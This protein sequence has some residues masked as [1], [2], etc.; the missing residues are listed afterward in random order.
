M[1]PVGARLAGA[2]GTIGVVATTG[3]AVPGAVDAWPAPS[4]PTDTLTLELVEPSFAIP[5]DTTWRAVYTVAGRLADVV[6][7]TTTTTT[8]TT[9]TT[10]PTTTRPGRGA[11]P[12]PDRT[13]TSTAPPT[14]TALAPPSVDAR[15]RVVLYRSLDE[16]SELAATIAGDLP[17][18]I[19]RFELPLD[20]ALSE[21]GN[22]S[23]LSVEVP[24]TT[25][26]NPDPALSMRLPGLYPIGVQLVV[27]GEV[28]A[29]HVTFVDRLPIDPPTNPPLSVAILAATDDPGPAPT[30]TELVE[31]REDLEAIADV[32]SS[33][34]GPVTVVLPPVLMADLSA[35]DE[36]AETLVTALDGAEL[37][38]QPADQ[39]DPS[40]AVAIGA[41]DAFTR[42]LRE[43]EDALAA[44]LPGITTRRSAWLV[45]SPISGAAAAELRN[46]GFR[47]LVFD[48][49][50][51]ESLDGN[52][53]AFKDPTLAVET[54][55]ND[56]FALPA[57]VVPA[58][59]VLLD[60]SYI[61]AAGITPGDAAVRLLAELL[62]IRRE[63]GPQRRRGVV[64]ATPD[65]G[66]PDSEAVA[67]FTALAA[68]L[69]KV[70]VVP[71]SV[72]PGATDTMRLR[73]RPVT[74]T[75]PEE[76]GIDLS[77]R[78]QRINLTRVF[79]ESA[80]SMM[81]DDTPADAWRAELDTLLSTGLDDEAVD[82]A[83]DRISAEAAAVRDSVAVPEPFP[84]TLT[85]RESVLRLNI[86]NDANEPRRVV[87]RARSPKLDFPEGDLEVEL[88]PAGS[89]EIELPVIARSNGTS[90]VEIELLT[91]AFGQTVAGPAVLSARVN[92]LTGL[93]QVITGGA[94]LVLLS[95]WFGHFRRRRRAR[96]ERNG[97][98]TGKA[99][100]PD[101][102]PDA[103]E[104]IARHGAP[105]GSVP[106]P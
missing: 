101:V 76:A 52:L 50:T 106:D 60:P 100:V 19:D 47:L 83:L 42:E 46:L 34:A 6:P 78:A 63:L 82:A 38:S 4:Q 103:A 15:V 9:A 80:A 16:R 88:A 102:S 62:T 14:S 25:R 29:D 41:T 99:A 43:G 59:G 36:L 94:V 12:R 66:V 64:L 70:E 72:L 3:W 67:T 2:V 26:P 84:F 24:T 57:M 17:N 22:T 90:S 23:R 44:A 1:T 87:V 11:T 92:A 75:L 7:P 30:F 49:D 104:A 69:P 13:T 20:G 45:T 71:L 35:D 5:A 33:A 58:S 21:S 10:P 55:L 79:A 98:R 85:G 51:Y 27:D 105:A 56:G 61:A 39:M 74:V 53:G 86:R 68:A 54:D 73:R 28:V 81:A 32:A 65:I 40:S 31:G 8:T 95:W 91:P 97:R 89:T 96:L 18:E 77:A 93:G 48:E 37:L